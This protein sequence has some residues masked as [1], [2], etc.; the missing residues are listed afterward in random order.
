MQKP[1]ILI[2]CDYYLPGFESGGAMRTIVNMT[3]RLGDEFDFRIV[4]RDHDGPNNLTPYPGVTID[5]WNTGGATPIYYLSRSNV[6]MPT[7]RRL[8]AEARPDAIYLNS[9]FSPLTVFVLTLRKL[10]RIPPIPV[11]LAPEGEFSRGALALKPA[12]KRLYIASAKTTGLLNDLVWK[13]G[14]EPE[15]E[16]ILRVLGRMRDNTGRNAS[17]SE[18]AFTESARSLTLAFPPTGPVILVAANMPPEM[19]NE[20]YVQ[21]DKPE[22][23]AGQSKMVFLSR[24]MRKKNF[25]WLLENL[26][27]LHGELTIDVCG[28]VE[29][30]DYWAETQELIETL[31]SNIRIELKGPVPH[32]RVGETLMQYHFFILPTLGENFGHVFIEALAAGC[33]LIISDRTPWRGLELQGIGWDLPLEDPPQWT[34]VINECVQMDQNEFTRM[35]QTARRFAVEW[36]ADPGLETANRRV[37]RSA[38]SVP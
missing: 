15:R 11:I 21:S 26:G 29:E 24:F 32:D 7:I 23:T 35:S 1:F 37:L 13:A 14:S 36:L 2:I 33:P 6:R 19:V 16:D 3:A 5:G 10:G 30:K 18:R 8:I 27:E 22:K 9:F 34:A 4:T 28:P 20:E 25:N 38:T 31:P 17:V 12:K